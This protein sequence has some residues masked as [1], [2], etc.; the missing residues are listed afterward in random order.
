M[1][2]AVQHLVR[3]GYKRLALI[4]DVQAPNN[5]HYFVESLRSHRLSVDEDR[6]IMTRTR[7]EVGGYQAA[8]KA[9]E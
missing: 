5:Y 6:M 7:G 3:C 2:L 4:G 8:L 9:T 1:N